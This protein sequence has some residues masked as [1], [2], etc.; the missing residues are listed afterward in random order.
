[1]IVH[2]VLLSISEDIT[3]PEFNIYFETKSLVKRLDC[4]YFLY[5]VYE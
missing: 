1:M 2:K 4:L 5:I 3:N